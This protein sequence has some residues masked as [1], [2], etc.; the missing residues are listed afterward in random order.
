[1][2]YPFDRAPRLGVNTVAQ[3][4]TSNM[5]IQ[6]TTIRFSNRIVAALPSRTQGQGQA[7][8]PAQPAAGQG[9]GTQQG[10]TGQSNQG[11]QSGQGNRGTGGTQPPANRPGGGRPQRPCK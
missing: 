2:G 6:N 1:M 7:Q 5:F 4:L 11:G 10:Q 3:F 8:R 9:T